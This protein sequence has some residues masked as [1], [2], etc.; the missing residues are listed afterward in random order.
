MLFSADAAL[1][2]LMNG[3]AARNLRHIHRLPAAQTNLPPSAPPSVTVILAARDEEERI[4]N[5]LR[6]LL[7]IR[8]V[9][10]EIV[11][12]DDRSRDRTPEILDRV[13]RENP[14]VHRIRV[15][16]LPDGWL[17][18]CHACQLG[19][20]K[21]QGHWLLFTDADCWIQ[22]DVLSR[23]IQTALREKADHLALTP[24]IPPDHLSG[25]AWHCTYPVLVANWLAGVN[26]D[27]RRSYMGVGAF[28]LLT[29]EAY[30]AV[31]GHETLRLTV[32]DDVKLGLLLRRAGRRTRV[33][34]GGPEVECHWGHTAWG[35]L[36]L[37]EKNCFAMVDYRI[38]LGLGGG[39]FPLAFWLLACIGPFHGSLPG[40]LAWAGLISFML[41]AARVARRL[42]WSPWLA[43]LTPFLIPILPLAALN[44]TLR[45]L[46]RGGVRWRDTFYPLA[47]LRAH[48]V[49]R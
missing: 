27:R 41:P 33:Y 6:H 43:L 4:E 34:L 40:W 7:E 38:V 39:I 1:W 32:V 19:A 5:T 12:V 3:A 13:C 16:K 17:G 23:A 49:R 24:G 42:G 46:W 20:A 9:D 11:V 45:T 26:R 48:N 31:G 21:A 25:M 35:I 37:T 22:P 44:S 36:G 18:K 29:R 30:Q 8:D 28:N 14:R 10:L 47:L 2:F 15:D